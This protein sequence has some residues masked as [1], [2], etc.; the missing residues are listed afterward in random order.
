MLKRRVK[1]GM[2][3]RHLRFDFW[4]TL[5]TRVRHCYDPSSNHCQPHP[6]Q[7]IT[8][9]VALLAFIFISCA[10]SGPATEQPGPPFVNDGAIG[11]AFASRAS[12]IQV[13]GEGTV[14][15]VLADDLNAPQ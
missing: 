8:T 13:E 14:I 10:S 9:V 7:T 3:L 2:H 11:R 6:K 4:N 12:N 15:R 5:P 1:A